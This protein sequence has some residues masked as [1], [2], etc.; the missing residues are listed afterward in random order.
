MWPPVAV[1]MSSFP[2]SSIP[3]A[4]AVSGENAPLQ[5]KLQQILFFRLAVAVFFLLLTL[6]VQSRRE[7]DLLSAHLQPLYFF[8]CILFVFTVVAGLALKRLHSPYHKAFAY[9]QLLFDAGAVTILI[10][11][12]GGVESSFSFLYMPVIISGAVLLHRSGSVLMASVCSLCY[13]LLLDLQYFGWLNPIQVMGEGLYPRDSGTYFQNIL[14]N[15]VG[16]YLVAYLGGYLA[17]ELHKSGQ[18]VMEQRR[19]IRQLELLHRNIV[20]SMSSGL[21]TMSLAGEIL[22]A[23][24]AA[25]HILGLEPEEIPGRPFERLFPGLDPSGWSYDMP[26]RTLDSPSGINRLE[27]SY[28]TPAG[29]EL[30]LGYTVSVLQPRDVGIAGWVFIFQDLTQ[31]KRMQSHLQRAERMAFAGRIAAEIAHEIKNPLA[32]ISGAVQMLNMGIQR[33]GSHDRLMNIVHREIDRIDDLLTDFLWLARGAQRSQRVENVS[34]RAM[35]EEV[36]DLLRS[37]D[38]IAGGHFIHADCGAVPFLSID[39]HH[40]RQILWNL[41]LNALQAMPDG[42]EVF[43]RTSLSEDGATLRR[44]VRLDVQDEGSG[45]PP[46]MLDRIFEP[47]CTTKSGGTGLGLSIVYQLVQNVGGRIE[48]TGRIDR[49]GTVFS[50]FFPL[51]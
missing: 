42:G 33:E 19:S 48:V 18:K 17:E 4:E 20:Q 15:I 1:E 29:E 25:S 51:A 39:P 30:Y 34:L 16:F 3:A 8:S 13:G 22:F 23:N 36:V 11:I 27:T 14:M 46:D 37:K 6:G 38:K 28:H 41:V 31:M 43:I 32:A 10:Y 9:V 50:L 45:I 40:L 5:R 35:V 7:G 44:A 26:F 12:S 21:L 47:F 2:T 24:E 49:P